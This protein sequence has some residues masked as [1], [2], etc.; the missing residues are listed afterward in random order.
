[1]KFL[2]PINLFRARAFLV[3][4]FRLNPLSYCLIILLLQKQRMVNILRAG[5]PVL[6][7]LR[8]RYPYHA[9]AYELKLADEYNPFPS[10]SP[11]IGSL[12]PPLPFNVPKKWT[13]MHAIKPGT[14]ESKS[15][16]SPTETE[17]ELLYSLL[18]CRARITFIKP[19]YFSN[20][21]LVRSIHNFS[22]YT[23]APPNALQVTVC[24]LISSGLTLRFTK[25]A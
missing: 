19:L 20:V 23:V 6:E 4:A 3:E 22:A 14:E 12:F 10:S 9:M 2:K 18:R 5:A 11:P 21:N 25:L 8:I 24:A 13:R 16:S 7:E 15:I 1:M 17:L